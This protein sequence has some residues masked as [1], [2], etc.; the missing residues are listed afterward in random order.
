MGRG[1]RAVVIRAER[2][3][4]A[5]PLWSGRLSGEE[6]GA[7]EV[8][9]GIDWSEREKREHAQESAGRVGPSS[10]ERRGRRGAQLVVVERGP[11]WKG[12][13]PSFPFSFISSF[14]LKFKYTIDSNIFIKQR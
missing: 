6:D 9:S 13:W 8:T 5:W 10:R 3:R 2:A 7:D 14:G 1:L 4:W 12:L 11:G